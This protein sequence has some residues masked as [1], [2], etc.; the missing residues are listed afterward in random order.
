MKRI[1]NGRWV[2]FVA[3]L[4]IFILSGCAARQ[5]HEYGR[6]VPDKSVTAQFE[7]YRVDPGMVYYISG[8]DDLPNAIIGIGKDYTLQSQLWKRR[9]FD[10]DMLKD[11]VDIMQNRVLATTMSLH[12]FRIEA[13]G[14]GA[15][16]VWFSILEATTSVK[17]E[18]R[19]VVLSTPPIDTY[20]RFEMRR[21]DK[22]L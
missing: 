16:G 11:V 4:C 9:D 7:E 22:S 21:K 18:D 14:G 6:F 19:N 15:V 13:P 2:L 5:M 10:E 8:S 12:G 1:R 3:V 20:E 17:V